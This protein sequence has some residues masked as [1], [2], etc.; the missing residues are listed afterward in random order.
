[1]H[2]TGSLLDAAKSRQAIPSDYK[3]AKALGV[4]QARISGY[5]IGKSRPDDLTARKIAELADLDEGYVVACLHAERAQNEEARG[6][7][8]GIAKRLERAGLAA[9]TA[10]FAL[11]FFGNPDAG[12]LAKSPDSASPVVKTSDCTAYTL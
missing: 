4:S 2:D 8:E 1:M 12:A 5:R 11:L 7:W 6:L 9:V 10:V 3:L